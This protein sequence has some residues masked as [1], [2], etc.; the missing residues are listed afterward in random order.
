MTA[1]SGSEA[2]EIKFAVTSTNITKL[3][4]RLVVELERIRHFVPPTLGVTVGASPQV[5]DFGQLQPTVA[6]TSDEDSIGIAPVG[7]W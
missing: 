3:Q 2:G 5:V 4:Q 1:T 7:R 6:P